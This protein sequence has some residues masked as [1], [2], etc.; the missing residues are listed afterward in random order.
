MITVAEDGVVRTAVRRRSAVTIGSSGGRRSSY[1]G[2]RFRVTR[3]V[4][5]SIDGVVKFKSG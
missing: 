2:D 4:V 3:I 5:T 1:G